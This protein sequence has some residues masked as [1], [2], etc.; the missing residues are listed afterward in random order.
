MKN[1]SRKHLVWM[2]LLASTTDVNMAHAGAWPQPLHHI[3]IIVPFSTTHASSAYDIQGKLVRRNPYTKEEL[4]PYVE[5]GLTTH[6]TLVGQMSLLHEHTS[7]LGKSVVQRSLSELKFGARFALGEWQK[8]YFSIQ[9]LA[10]WHG[11][12]NE[13]DPFASQRGDIDGEFAVTLG[14]HF[15]WLGFDGFTDNLIG[16]TLRPANRPSAFKVN[17]TLGLDLNPRTK[18]MLKSESYA[19]FSKGA[20]ASQVQSNKLGLSFVR[21]MDKTVSLEIGAATSLTGRNTIE[22]RSVRLALWYDF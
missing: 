14:R 17:L 3:Q 19:A 10:I 2:L 9:P 7:W 21:R 1:R 4:A 8:T 16:I 22:E 18:I 11:S 12:M 6:T 13:S 15:K 5:Y 20:A